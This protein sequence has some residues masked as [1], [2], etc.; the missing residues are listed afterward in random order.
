MIHRYR[1]GIPWRGLPAHFGD[2]NNTHRRHR[3]WAKRGVWAAIFASLA[4]DADNESAMIDSTIV[5]ALQ[6][7]AGA[8]KVALIG[9][10]VGWIALPPTRRPET[11][12]ALC[13]NNLFLLSNNKRPIVIRTLNRSIF[14]HRGTE[15]FG[16]VLTLKTGVFVS[17]RLRPTNNA[18]RALPFPTTQQQ[19]WAGARKPIVA[20]TRPI[21]V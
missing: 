6:H 16:P 19:K 14:H 21:G 13:G 2:W 18:M 11:A 1:T 17:R 15:G 5:R 7:S 4:T 12:E 20:D 3:G 8:K 10:V 9:L